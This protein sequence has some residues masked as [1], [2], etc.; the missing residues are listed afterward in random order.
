[1][2][3]FLPI[4]KFAFVLVP[5]PSIVTFNFLGNER[6]GLSINNCVFAF[7]GSIGVLYN[8]TVPSPTNCAL[9]S[10]NAKSWFWL[11]V[12]IVPFCY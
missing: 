5:L 6:T 11:A 9:R 12:Q 8:L 1:M 4:G 3:T 7:P 10:L 2:L